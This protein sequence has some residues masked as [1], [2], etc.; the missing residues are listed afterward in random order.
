MNRCI[1]ALVAH[2]SENSLRLITLEI[3][4]IIAENLESV[5]VLW[6]KNGDMK[7][8]ED[9][10]QIFHDRFINLLPENKNGN[11]FENKFLY[12]Y[13]INGCIGMIRK[14]IFEEF[15]R[16]SP[17]EVTDMVLRITNANVLI[18]KLF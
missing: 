12:I 18:D 10:A 3:I 15:N 1:D 13:M 5:R 8:Q 11:K 14:W 9:M 17:E 2:P 7:F 4:K 16:I 6:G